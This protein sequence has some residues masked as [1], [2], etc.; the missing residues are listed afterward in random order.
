MMCVD[1]KCRVRFL[2][3]RWEGT[4]HDSRVL[5]DA[6][7]TGFLIPRGKFAVGDAGYGELELVL[8][9]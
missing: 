3:A 6:R 5:R 2:L 4:V 7:G 1:H 8:T 9:P